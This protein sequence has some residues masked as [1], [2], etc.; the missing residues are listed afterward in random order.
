MGGCAVFFVFGVALL[1][2]AC[3]TLATANLFYGP[4]LLFTLACLALLADEVV[5]AIKGAR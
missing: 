3:L 2:G 4:A 1:A 5:K